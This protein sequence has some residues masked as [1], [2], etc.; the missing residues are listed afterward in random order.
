MNTNSGTLQ[1]TLP[2]DPKPFNDGKIVRMTIEIPR[3]DSKARDYVD[4]VA[5]GDQA[6]DIQRWCKAGTEVIAT[7]TLQSS[8]REVKGQMRYYQDTVITHI[9]PV[10]DAKTVA[11]QAADEAEAE[12]EP[13]EAEA[14]AKPARARSS[15]AKKADAKA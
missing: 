6:A 10:N 1:G 9:A 11:E 8:R 3:P 15:R 13:A 4:T 14:E 5:F 7:T 12:A 2:R